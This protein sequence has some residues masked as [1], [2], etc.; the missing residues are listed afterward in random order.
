MLLS[1]TSDFGTRDG[2][3]AA[4]KGVLLTR[5]PELQ[6]VDVSHEIPPGD[7]RAGAYVL[8]LAAR[9]FPPG[10][11][12]LAVV[13]PRVGSERRGVAC[14]VAESIFVGPDNGLLPLALEGRGVIEVFELTRRELWRESVSPVF[15]GRDLFAPVAAWLAA[16][17]R[18]EEVGPALSPMSLVPSPWPRAERVGRSLRG[19]VV[20]VDRFG[21]LITN[22]RPDPADAPGGGRVTVGEQVLPLVRSYS[23]AADGALVA[24]VGSAGLLEVACNRGSASER[25][26]ASRGLV[27]SYSPR[28]G[29][30]RV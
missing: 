16:G 23:D 9:E 22:I 8:S 11:L 26:S 20:H 10:T 6:I 29:G 5:A 2:Y 27:V 14:R 12:H 15:H 17:G 13:D 3:V 1:F 24:L 7:V 19:E 21:N 30:E 4:V 28:A 25:L 18:L